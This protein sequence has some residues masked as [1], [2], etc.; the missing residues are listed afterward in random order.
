[1]RP[2]LLA[3]FLTVAVL[4]LF[5]MGRDRFG[6]TNS[7]VSAREAK[8]I[9]QRVVAN[10]QPTI[11]IPP[12][13]D[14]GFVTVTDGDGRTLKKSRIRD[15]GAADPTSAVTFDANVVC[16]G[17]VNCTGDLFTGDIKAVEVSAATRVTAPLVTATQLNYESLITPKMEKGFPGISTVDIYDPSG[18]PA[19]QSVDGQFRHLLA[20]NTTYIFHGAQTYTNGFTMGANTSVQGAGFSATLTFDESGNDITGFYSRDENVYLSNIT[21]VGGGGHLF[22]NSSFVGLFDC[23]NFDS[24]TAPPPFYGRNKRFKVTN[25]NI[26]K[27]WKFGNVQ[28]YGT[29][30]ITNNFFNGGGGD[31]TPGSV[32][33]KSGLTVADGLSL[34]F[35]QNK[36]V[37][38]EGA[39]N[40]AASGALLSLVDSDPLLGFNAVN[41]GNNIFHPRGEEVGL[42]FSSFANTKLGNITGNNFIRTGGS[43]ALIGYTA[44]DDLKNYNARALRTYEVFGNAG[45]SDSSP[46]ISCNAVASNTFNNGTSGDITFPAEN[47]LSS[48]ESR[49]L[50][51]SFSLQGLVDTDLE[52]GMFI[53]IQ[54]PSD[55][56]PAP[57]SPIYTFLIAK[58]NVPVSGNLTIQTVQLVDF[59]SPTLPEGSNYAARIYQ[60]DKVTLYTT[61]SQLLLGP[62]DNLGILEFVYLDALSPNYVAMNAN[63]SLIGDTKNHSHDFQ[64]AKNI[65]GG[66]Y[67]P[68]AATI[69]A[70]TVSRDDPQEFSVVVSLGQTMTYGDKFKL[71]STQVDNS[72]CNITRVSIIGK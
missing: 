27:P 47:V 24:T 40:P 16:T 35:T 33:T 65:Q 23:Q 9:A 3:T 59:S 50:G 52:A 70:I 29:I 69:S 44:Y 45:I 57:A 15:L 58:A 38:F 60:A 5:N 19:P 37:L 2:W 53:E 56:P 26:L 71:Q 22:N 41:I 17:D 7:G 42:L 14:A 63:I 46:N 55:P 20:D 31:L 18:L 49:R 61:A 1:M 43:G 67:A 72:G 11:I 13:G 62:R 12:A 25:V 66:G 28:G 54:A 32:Y 10:A 6:N 39:T 34:E 51:I 68:D 4:T 30:N 48:K 21:I 8:V 36:I 64:W